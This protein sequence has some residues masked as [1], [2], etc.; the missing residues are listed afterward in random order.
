[1]HYLISRLNLLTK[2][3]IQLRFQ[4]RITLQL[5]VTIV[6]GSDG[7]N[8]SCPVRNAINTEEMS[9]YRRNS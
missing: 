2:A 7:F 9:Y 5:L 3:G 4:K 6:N 8:D 1:L